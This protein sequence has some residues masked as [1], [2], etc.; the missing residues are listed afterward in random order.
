MIT[1]LKFFFYH[2][3]WY[4]I[5]IFGLFLSLHISSYVWHLDADKY[6]TKRIPRILAN[7]DNYKFSTELTNILLINIGY[8]ILYAITMLII[9]T[10]GKL[11]IRNAINSTSEKMLNIDLSKISK[12][13]YEHDIV[14]I[15]HH[16]ENVT[17]A[18]RNLFI[19]F[20]RKIVAC[21]HFLIAL[22]EL[23]FEIM[24]YCTI[25]N[26]I[27]VLMTIT[28]SYI[29]KYLLSKVVDS[30]INFSVVCAD[31]SS[32]IQTY[33]I[34]NRLEEYQNKINKLTSDIW[35]YSSLD[36][37]MIASNESVTSFSGQ[38]MIGLISYMCRPMVINNTISI[39]DLM[40]GVRS[41]SKF[42]E[43]MIGILEYFGDVIRQ[44][45]S[46][47][48]FLSAKNNIETEIKSRNKDIA[49]I[50]IKKGITTY[51]Y[52]IGNNNGKLIHI[53]G[54]NGV[55]KTTILLKFLGVSYK[56]ATSKGLIISY[57]TNNNTLLPT[58]YRNNISF[59]QQNIP[60]THDSIKEYI[61][62]VSK[63]NKNI[64]KLLTETLDY[65]E[66]ENNSKKQ[67]IN[68]V[69]SLGINKCIREL[70]GG[71]AKFI[72]IIAAIIKLYA[73]KGNILVLDEPSNNLDTEKVNYV[74]EIINSCTNKDIMVFIVT[75]DNRMIH[76][77]NV[78]TID[79]S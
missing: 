28:I 59:V 6:L 25:A 57:D 76:V 41:S 29:R 75:H 15:V 67:I 27:F 36:S 74:K 9:E 64:I 19:E 72:Q 4:Q 2:L 66:I 47:N 38:F 3:K 8:L 33:K 54:P 24:M 50:N 12:K 52:D 71:Q 13:Q 79:L 65:F 1:S 11:A 63:S 60:T 26:I 68:F 46:F 37:L 73:L 44:Y 30:N 61:L 5:S 35:C 49:I 62:A 51:K 55:G 78:E 7:P 43:K 45:K 32:S 42:I 69:D 40:Y 16:S 48:F 17:S 22:R 58:S 20:P 53:A 77:K 10:I 23:S 31:L 70:S 21:H 18:I 34:D 14:S 39:E 56:S